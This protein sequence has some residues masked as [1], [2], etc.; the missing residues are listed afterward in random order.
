MLAA[1]MTI[2]GAAQMVRMLSKGSYDVTATGNEVGTLK[3]VRVKRDGDKW[4]AE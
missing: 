4:S 3:F 2:M 1:T